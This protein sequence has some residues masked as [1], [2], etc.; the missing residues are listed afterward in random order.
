M[1]PSITGI[2][3]RI[4][5]AIDDSDSNNY[6]NYSNNYNNYNN[7][8][9]GTISQAV[10]IH[11]KPKFKRR[12]SNASTAAPATTTTITTGKETSK[13]EDLKDKAEMVTFHL[14]YTLSD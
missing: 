7:E 12:D 9:N 5:I 13:E 2:S 4:A 14:D 1:L 8:I 11:Q 6:H 3:R 10:T